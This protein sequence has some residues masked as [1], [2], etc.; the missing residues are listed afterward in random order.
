MNDVSLSDCVGSDGIF[1]DGDW[2]ESKDQDPNGEV[3]LIQLADIGVGSFLDK[4]ARFLTECPI[5]LAVRAS[6]LVFR[7]PAL[8][9]SMYAS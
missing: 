9:W 8:Q 3:R 1:T 6:S 2:V 5:R 4:S 7:S